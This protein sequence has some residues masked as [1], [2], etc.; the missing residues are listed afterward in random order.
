ML[1]PRHEGFDHVQ[2]EA[3]FEASIK[4]I[5][6]SKTGAIYDEISRV[7]GTLER[8]QHYLA[9]VIWFA[10]FLNLSWWRLLYIPICDFDI[11]FELNV[12]HITWRTL[13]CF[14]LSIPKN[15]PGLLRRVVG[16]A[17]RKAGLDVTFSITNLLGCLGYPVKMRALVLNYTFLTRP[18]QLNSLVKI[19][20]HHA[21]IDQ[22]C[23]NHEKIIDETNSN[24]QVYTSTYKK[25]WRTKDLHGS[26]ALY[27]VVTLCPLI[28]MH[29]LP[30]RFT[31]SMTWLRCSLSRGAMACRWCGCAWEIAEQQMESITINNQL[32]GE[33]IMVN[34]LI[35]ETSNNQK[36]L[37]MVNDG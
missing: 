26:P 16:A 28:S 33:S 14:C 5:S 18:H 19:T 36:W 9:L 2:R 35:I 17:Y 10:R 7:G 1:S 13:L 15:I 29:W 6:D 24:Q 3:N 37:M 12:E 30:K 11:Y 8:I 4:S 20:N 25:N 34:G 22:W 23:W 21:T 31:A 27:G 32:I